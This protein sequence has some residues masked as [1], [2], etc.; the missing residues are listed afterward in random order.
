[1]LNVGFA[2]FFIGIISKEQVAMEWLI[3][4]C[5]IRQEFSLFEWGPL[6]YNDFIIKVGYLKQKCNKIFC[7]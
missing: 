1:M 4:D 6:D 5:R 7:L 2:C 3:S